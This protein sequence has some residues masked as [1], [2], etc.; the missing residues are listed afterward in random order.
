MN[1]ISKSKFLLQKLSQVTQVL[2]S[3]LALFLHPSN[4]PP[5]S[6]SCDQ[7]RSGVR[8]EAEAVWGAAGNGQNVFQ[9]TAQFR[10]DDV[11]GGV[12]TEVA[13]G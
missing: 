1:S 12:D 13:R 11:S 5:L 8:P 10:A 6:T 9:G 2:N 7:R 4:G 3:I